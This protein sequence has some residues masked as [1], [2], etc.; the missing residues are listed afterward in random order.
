M[1]EKIFMIISMLIFGSIGLIV[2]GIPLSSSQIAM[3]RGLIGSLF[4]IIASIIMKKKPSYKEIKRNLKIL[5]AS[6]AALGFNWILLFE[7]YKNTSITNATLSYYFAPVIVVFLSPLI[8]KDK[9]T[10]RKALSILV[11]II[12]MFLVAWTGGDGSIAGNEL[13]GIGFGL[14]A[15]FLYALVVIFNKLIKNMGGFDITIIQLSIAS[16]I[17]LPYVLLQGPIPLNLLNASEI[18]RLLLVGLLNTGL[19]YL[20]YFSS[21]QKLESQTVAV[22]SYID[23]I[24]ALVMSAIFVGEK[25]SG[26]QL[27]GGILI[28]GSAFVSGM[29][30]RP[31]RRC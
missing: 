7:A 1:K 23:P 28:L 6:G 31:N 13:L 21:V 29:N 3:T 14:S 2:K 9:L 22:F 5:I 15:A 27:M 16:M 30:H 20:L 25:I 10:L 12:G 4:L 18:I 26:L 17:L 19:A 11:A 24:S 8:L